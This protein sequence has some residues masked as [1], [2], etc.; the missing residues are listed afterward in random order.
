MFKIFKMLNP[1]SLM[2]KVITWF[3]EGISPKTRMILVII[4]FM[5]IVAIGLTGYEIN[6][7][8]E[9]DPSSCMMCHVHD[10]ANKAWATSVHNRV[11][12]HQCHLTTKKDQI[13]QL[14]RFAV[15]GDR[16]V[17]PRHGAIIVAWKVCEKCHWE[18]NPKF[19]NAPLVNKSR[20]HAKHFFL[21]QIECVKC[22]G[23]VTHQFVPD[24]RFCIRCHKNREV[25][26]TGM[27]ALAC[28]NCHTDRTV[29]LKPSRNKCLFCHG[30]E[31]VRK[32]LIAAGSIDVKYFKPSPAL[33]NRAVKINVP[34]DAPMQFYCYVCHKPHAKVKPD[35]GDCLACH[36]VE[37]GVGKHSLHIKTMNMK[38][39]DC[40]K[41]HIWHITPAQAKTTCTKCHE[42]RD[43]SKFIGP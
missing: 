29:D 37:P 27:E 17:S 38:C 32:E 15:L 39:M 11:G 42:Y 9:N 35:M 36:K 40:H 8:F 10:A 30:G 31:Q 22:H 13:L 16:T 14:Y 26:G 33:I 1:F 41:P 28:I 7:Y 24:E 19:P 21:E 3:T 18:R 20:F 4:A 25:H 23:F 43:P 2:E 34:A 5:F 6:E 12:C